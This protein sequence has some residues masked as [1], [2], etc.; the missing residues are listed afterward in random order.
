M[1]PSCLASVHARRIAARTPLP[2]GAL[3]PRRSPRAKPA[4]FLKSLGA[5]A[6]SHRATTPSVWVGVRPIAATDHLLRRFPAGRPPRPRATRHLGGHRLP[7][8]PRPPADRR[9]PRHRIRT[10]PADAGANV[11]TIGVLAGH[12]DTPPP[13]PSTPPSATPRSSTPWKKAAAVSAALTAS[14]WRP[15]ARVGS[16]RA[17]PLS[18]KHAH[19]A[20]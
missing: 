14:L 2:T 19:N 7:P 9:P 10:H 5:L 1:G 13:P 8:R 16:A 20:G 11:D 4:G 3:T 12:A 6:E 15:I 18:G 17:R